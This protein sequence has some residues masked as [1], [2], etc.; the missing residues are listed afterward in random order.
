MNENLQGINNSYH[1]RNVSNE[2]KKN[3]PEQDNDDIIKQLS[4]ITPDDD[5][6]FESSLMMTKNIPKFYEYKCDNNGLS[7]DSNITKSVL[8]H[9][10]DQKNINEENLLSNNKY[11][12][13]NHKLKFICSLIQTSN[14]NIKKYDDLIQYNTYLENINLLNHYEPINILFDIISELIF[15]IQKEIKN[16]NILM[17]EIKRLKY[18]KNDNEKLIYKLKYSIK[19]KDEELNQI[20][21]IKNDKFYKY[22]LDEIKGLKQ[23]NKEL[24]KKINIYKTQMKKVESNNN[25]ILN[26]LNTFKKEKLIKTNISSNLYNCRNIINIPSWNNLNKLNNS[27]DDS[28]CSLVKKNI[29]KQNTNF[30]FYKNNNNYKTLNF[31]NNETSPKKIISQKSLNNNTINNMYNHRSNNNFIKNDENNINFNE[32]SIIS[33]M[34]LLLKDIN[35]MLNLYSSSLDNFN[36]NNKK[37]TI[38]GVNNLNQNIEKDKNIEKIMSF[39]DKMEG[40]I[41]KMEENIKKYNENKRSNSKKFIQ[42]NT[43]R[44]KFKK[45]IHKKKD[46]KENNSLKINE[47]SF[48]SPRNAKI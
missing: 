21:S 24:Y 34:R 27:Y 19:Q 9:D 15:V 30:D 7:K 18:Y 39:I 11:L 8:L 47:D 22:N 12:L 42:V 33:N 28:K 35:N 43:S 40:K 45:K 16:N 1:S 44:W 41:K 36:F 10:I 37:T 25:I 3:F 31:Y 17:R 48:S 38:E 26:K 23:E 46:K 20:K 14:I 4:Q 13:L 32:K 5:K 2:N 6:S 29:N